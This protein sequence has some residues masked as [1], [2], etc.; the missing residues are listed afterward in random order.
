MTRLPACLKIL[1]IALLLLAAIVAFWACLF[2]A[3][4]FK[5]QL[6]E[7]LVLSC[8]DMTVWSGDYC[9][10]Q[11]RVHNIPIY[12]CNQDVIPED[13]WIQLYPLTGN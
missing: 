10:Q 12:R 11:A 8:T 4:T 9:I 3:F 7:Q 13:R 1:L 6:L 2:F 5:Q